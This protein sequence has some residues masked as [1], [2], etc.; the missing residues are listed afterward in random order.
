MP[1]A[2]V[3]G[4]Y[5]SHPRAAYFGT[6]KIGRDQVEDYAR[7]KG[8]TLQ[9]AVDFPNIVAR[10]E[11]VYVE[12]KAE[13]GSAIAEDLAARGYKLKKPRFENSGVHVILVEGDTLKGAADPR[14]EGTVGSLP[15]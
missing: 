14:R 13:P 7:R 10:G 6:G 4:L 5:F 8:M 1:T 2:S 11:K 15:R 3:S 12:T 9:D